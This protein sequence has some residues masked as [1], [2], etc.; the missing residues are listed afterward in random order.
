MNEDRH[1]EET[2]DR[3][4]GSVDRSGVW[5]SIEAR[6]DARAGGRK[7]ASTPRR[8]SGLRVA[9]YACVAAVLVAALAMGSLEAVRH[10]GN[11]QP[12]LVITDQT[13][14]PSTPGQTT[15]TTVSET[16]A[17]MYRG[18]LE[19]TGVYRGGG[20]T[21]VPELVWKFKTGGAVASSPV[22]SDGVVYFGSADGYLYAVDV[23]TGQERWTFQTG[24]AV[25][26]SPAVSDGVAYVSSNDDY[27]YALDAQ[28]GQEKWKFRTEGWVTSSPAISDSV[29]YFG[30]SDTHLYAVGIQTGQER[31]RFKAE[32][33]VTSSPAISD[34][35]VY[36]TDNASLYAV[37]VS[38]GREE[39]KFT[40]GGWAVGRASSP[41]ISAGV[42]YVCGGDGYL[43]ALDAQ[44]G[45]KKWDFLMAVYRGDDSAPA[46]SGGVIYAATGG[47][48]SSD[49]YLYAVDIRSGQERW[50]FQTY[51]ERGRVLTCAPAVSDGAVYFGGGPS[52]HA[53]DA[54]SGQERWKFQTTPVANAWGGHDFVSSPV[55]WEGVVFFGSADGYLYTLK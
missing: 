22:V 16:S 37:D 8:R 45:Q 27:L 53:L 10:L 6:A 39:W 36:F 48:D 13:T 51:S 28:S 17:A 15:E 4:S 1:L 18:N 19:R 12:I 52:L 21:E 11:G 38:T 55:I 20:P 30:S 47:G 9:V 23:Q 50:K 29:V 3:L 43:Y 32:Y 49:G 2:L 26:S 40:L 46:V 34:G 31:W 35:V 5:A 7:R 33:E 25:W 14:V 44:T 42:V 41:A 24:D 54:Q